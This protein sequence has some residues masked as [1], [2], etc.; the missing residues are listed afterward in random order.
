MKWHGATDTGSSSIDRLDLREHNL[1]C[2]GFKSP[3]FALLINMKDPLIEAVDA[4]VGTI[5]PEP[6]W[7]S[8]EGRASLRLRDVSR[9]PRDLL[10]VL[11]KDVRREHM[12]VL[13][14]C[15]KIRRAPYIST[16]DDPFLD[17]Q[18]WDTRLRC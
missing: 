14:G 2:L 7:T 18:S 9:S 16:I 1:Q 11:A 15:E 3:R 4:I 17:T 6:R 5:D 13:N 8:I 12:V 10:A